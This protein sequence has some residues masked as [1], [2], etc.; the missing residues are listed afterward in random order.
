[1]HTTALER[2]RSR[3]NFSFSIMAGAKPQED[4]ARHTG[5]AFAISSNGVFVTCAHVVNDAEEIHVVLGDESHAAEVVAFDR[6]KDVALL[7]I[8][9]D[10]LPTLPL[11]ES[12]EIQ[13]AQPV[14]LVGYPL[15]GLLGKGVKISSGTIT[16][17]V[18]DLGV[19]K[20]R[21]QVDATFNSGNSGGPIIDD[22]GAVVGVA[23]RSVFRP[24]YR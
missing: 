18:E 16:G 23:R 2:T 21:F 24:S 10:G 6:L 14:R 8:S 12:D 20:H 4:E 5:T 9:A 11:A 15:S 22:S 19:G 7:R 1:M 3:G 17:G 13:L